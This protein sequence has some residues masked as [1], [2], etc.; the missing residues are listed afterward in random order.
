MKAH[1]IFEKRYKGNVNLVTPLH[2]RYGMIDPVL[3][4]ELSEGRS[5]IHGNLYGVTV[6]EL[7]SEDEI[8]PRHGLSKCFSSRKEA[9]EYIQYLTDTA[10]EMNR[11][12]LPMERNNEV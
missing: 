9:E 11:K 6:L 8:V 12:F 2:I 3:A 4:Y 1:E 5:V 10:P 7:L